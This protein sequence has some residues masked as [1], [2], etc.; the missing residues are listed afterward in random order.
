MCRN[1]VC[2]IQNESNRLR[3]SNPKVC[4]NIGTCTGIDQCS[5]TGPTN[6][7]T[8]PSCGT[9]CSGHGTPTSVPLNYYRY[10]TFDTLK[11]SEFYGENIVLT[12]VDMTGDIVGRMYSNDCS[13]LRVFYHPTQ[14]DFT[15]SFE[16]ARDVTKCGQQTANIAFA[17]QKDA[18]NFNGVFVR[19]KYSLRVGGENFFVTSNMKHRT[20]GLLQFVKR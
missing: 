17:F 5:C 2:F 7:W 14:Y 12:N 20:T 6:K 19:G 3:A 13:D 15:G 18:P 16:I 4:G 1:N 10:F 9:P 8:G 11:N